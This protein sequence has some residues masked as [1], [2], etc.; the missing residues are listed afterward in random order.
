MF[1]NF[2]ITF[3]YTKLGMTMLVW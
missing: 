3:K 1:L 2:R